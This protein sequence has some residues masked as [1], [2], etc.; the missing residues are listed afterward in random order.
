MR[1]ALTRRGVR[2]V[3]LPFVL[4]FAVIAPTEALFGREEK[5]F[6]NRIGNPKPQTKPR[7]KQGLRLFFGLRT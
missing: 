3:T 5:R 4:T 7:S 1:A 6:A 2:H